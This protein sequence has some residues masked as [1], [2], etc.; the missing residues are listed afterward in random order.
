MADGLDDPSAGVS[1]RELR[2]SLE[3]AAA[4]STGGL[5]TPG[6]EGQEDYFTG[7]PVAAGS[8]KP[9]ALVEPAKI[10]DDS[11]PP[12][13][14]YARQEAS[15]KGKGVRLFQYGFGDNLCTAPVGLQGWCAKPK[16]ECKIKAH[17]K[18]E[19]LPIQEGLY[20]STG[21]G[22]A[23]LLEPFVPR[24]VAESIEFG[25]HANEDYAKDLWLSVIPTVNAAFYRKR[26]REL[27]GEESD[28]EDGYALASEMAMRGG[29]TPM[30][31]LRLAEG[32]ESDP[33]SPG[34]VDVQATQLDQATQLVEMIRS[35]NID[36]H[37]LAAL[38]GEAPEDCTSVWATL[39]P[40][41]SFL[42]THMSNIE[43]LSSGVGTEGSLLEALSSCVTR[44]G[45]FENR[46]TTLNNL[47]QSAATAAATAQSFATQAE[48]KIEAYTQS[49]GN[50]AI[51][52]LGLRLTTIETQD[53][54]RLE[55]T[56]QFVLE[57]EKA[58]DR[59]ERVRGNSGTG[60]HVPPATGGPAQGV[61]QGQLDTLARSLR[62]EMERLK[63]V[64]NGGGVSTPAGRF[65]SPTD[66]SLW[67]K[68][69]LPSK[70][71]YECFIDPVTALMPLDTAVYRED[72]E[73]REVHQ[74]KV[75]R[76]SHQSLIVASFQTQDPPRFAGPKD[77]KSDARHHYMALKD[78]NDWD[79]G[80]GST[81]MWHRIRESLEL[82]EESIN[83]LIDERLE[84]YD[85]AQLLCRHLLSKTVTFLRALDTKMRNL[86]RELLYKSH[87]SVEDAPE[88]AKA[89]CWR[90]VTTLLKVMFKEF[91]VVRVHAETGYSSK[92]NENAMYLHGTLMA[93]KVMEDFMKYEFTG[94]PKFYPRLIMHIYETSAPRALLTDLKTTVREQARTIT[95]LTSTVRTLQ[96]NLDRLTASVNSRNNHNNRNNNN[97]NNNRN[98]CFP[99]PCFAPV[100]TL[101]CHPATLVR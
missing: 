40:V 65:D 100:S 32:S 3:R 2:S 15:K 89:S 38:V 5:K 14:N 61:A 10:E 71:V 52:A 78:F 86:Y 30:K 24:E 96:G 50:G 39:A 49:G 91:R 66:S 26:D 87:G 75:G 29:P 42:N 77:G 98:H 34:A 17:L 92:G 97:N 82:L 67:C 25:P 59:L 79:S 7:T 43:L 83:A 28:G 36:V 33:F 74:A 20:I 57:L 22:D 13:I 84:G 54:A 21:R 76:C 19:P 93:H 46:L 12:S 51:N 95:T 44:V 58:I 64:V 72:V 69:N 101:R 88:D 23:N 68:T 47:A 81:G 55:Q 99:R 11:K 41:A 27:E 90:I 62:S 37:T 85:K 45:A 18:A 6:G 73:A 48:S 31:R 63:Q 35:V 1:R 4:A 56:M 16:G 80:D 70:T 9:P 8:L 94:H 53:R 60:S